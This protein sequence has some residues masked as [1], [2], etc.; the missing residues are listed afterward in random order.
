MLRTSSISLIAEDAL[1]LALGR[2][3]VQEH[4]ALS[5]WRETNARGC[6]A[7]K[8]DIRKYDKMARSGFPVFALTD[9]DSRVCCRLLLDEWFDPRHGPHSDMLLR[10]C[11][12]EA[13][14][15]LMA[16][17]GPL[18]RLLRLPESRFPSRPEILTDP[19]RFLL[20]LAIHAP[21]RVR[22][23]LL[24]ARGSTAS[25]GVEYNE[26]LCHLVATWN[27]GKAA[28][29]APSLAKARSRLNELA[30]RVRSMLVAP[31]IS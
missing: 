23:G 26:L 8:R 2:R 6:G 10:I 17:P 16:D 14:A 9:L 24:P 31:P 29:R 7:I 12:R 3:L 20:N 11:V 28:R 18:A 13:E 1:G 21:K 15:W 30:V 19:K 22:K 4:D 5:V 27:I 25:I